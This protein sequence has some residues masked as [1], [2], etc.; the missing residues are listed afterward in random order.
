MP[1][2]AKMVVVFKSSLTLITVC[3][4]TVTP[5]LCHQGGRLKTPLRFAIFI[6]WT[7]LVAGPAEPQAAQSP[8]ANSITSPGWRELMAD[9]DR[10]H[11]GMASVA[12]GGDSDSDF[13]RLMLPHHQA[14]IDMAKTELMYGKDPQVRRLA[15]EIITDQQSEI[16]L[17][18]LWIKKH[19]DASKRVIQTPAL[20]AG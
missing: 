19:A 4:L 2:D 15:Q 13:V 17:I 3:G 8:G 18:Q 1:V 9:M 10:M 16:D 11:A 7:L 14:A 5:R 6:T 20:H 12:S